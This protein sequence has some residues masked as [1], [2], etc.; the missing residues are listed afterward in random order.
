[1]SSST[2][3]GRA[4]KKQKLNDQDGLLQQYQ[5]TIAQ[6]PK[7]IQKKLN[8][9]TV[10]FPNAGF[11]R[12]N[13]TLKDDLKTME[14]LLSILKNQKATHNKSTN[15]SSHQQ[16]DQKDKQIGYRLSD[17]SGGYYS[18]PVPAVNEVDDEPFPDDFNWVDS[19]FWQVDVPGIAEP[20]GCKCIGFMYTKKKRLKSG[21]TENVPF[22][23]EC[24]RN[25]SCDES[26]IN[27]LVQHQTQLPL[28]LFKTKEK[29]W[30]VRTNQFIP[31]GSFVFEYAGEVID[32]DEAE[33]RGEEYDKKRCSYLFDLDYLNSERCLSIDALSHGNTARFVNHSCD[34]NLYIVP[35]EIDVIGHKIYHVGLFSK[36]DISPHE[37]LTYDY[38]YKLLDNSSNTI[39]CHCGAANCRGRLV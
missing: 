38:K 11:V 12:R 24:N 22:V 23:H 27:R 29:G 17:V 8:S 28:E 3:N 33:D 15:D 31:K 30:A 20:I 32:N 1:M 4:V 5:E 34:P 7:V 19:I 2:S 35:V 9:T 36:R 26:C 39:H 18:L 21:M 13:K 25:C 10:E 14:R 6:L 16:T 37:E